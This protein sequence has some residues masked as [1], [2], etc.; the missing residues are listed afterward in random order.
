MDSAPSSEKR[1]WP[2]YLVWMNCSSA[3]AA[4]SFWK[5]RVL[6]STSIGSRNC[7]PS[8]RS[9]SQRFS[10]GSEMCMNSDADVVRVRVPEPVEQVAERQPLGPRRRRPMP[11]VRKTRSRSHTVRP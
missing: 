11:P 4:L 6:R 5:M 9:M 1:L 8:M 2:M 7:V 10:S 3:S